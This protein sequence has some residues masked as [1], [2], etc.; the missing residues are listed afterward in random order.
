[1]PSTV[2]GEHA[3]TL[4][5][6]TTAQRPSPASTGMTRFNT[7]TGSLEFYNGENWIS[8][9]L[10]PSVV[11]VTGVIYAGSSSTLTLSI[12]NSTDT[13]TVRFKEGG[14]TIANVSDVTVT[15]GS[16]SVTV[17]S[18]VFGQTAGDTILVS[19]INIDGTPSSNEISKTVSAPPSG[20][21]VTTTG[22]YRVH[23]FTSSGSFVV[24]SGTTLSNVEYLV[25]GGGGGG[26]GPIS[27]GGGAGGYRTSVP[28]QTSGGNSSAESR[29][30]TLSA[31]TYSITVAAG[32]AGVADNGPGPS[33]QGDNS[34]FSSITSI[35]GGSS[36]AY[37]GVGISGGSGGGGARAPGPG[38]SIQ[39]GGAG[40]SG[41]GSNG[42]PGSNSGG[43]D[44]YGSG[45]GG[46][47]AGGVGGT[48]SGATGGTGGSGLSNNITGS[49]VTRSGGGGGG[50]YNGT[51]GPGG[52][53]GGGNGSPGSGPSATAGSTNTG[54]GGGAGGYPNTRAGAN[55]GSGLVIIRYIL[56]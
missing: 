54:S 49:A 52:P 22:S 39:P 6:G 51:G 23:T 29:I 26:G 20:G 14:T 2:L 31:G 56:T 13:V 33:G 12:L 43:G 50:A 21:T 4:P 46:G 5:S 36:P 53:G 55:G 47:G 9:N 42:G 28:G 19:V 41:Q 35:G 44:N 30:S 8:T 7:T 45:G 16:A 32:G 27:G 38:G 11:S 37:G 24:P 40:T 15:A 34:V 18:A 1:M 48:A 17:P 25:I 3:T 10:I